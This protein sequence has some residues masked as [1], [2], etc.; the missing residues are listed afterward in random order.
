MNR[1][2]FSPAPLQLGPLQLS[3][4]E[5]HHL[6]HVLRATPGD[7]ITLF[8]G[9]GGEFTAR[10]ESTARKTVVCQILQA[11]S[12]NRELPVE[13]VLG[14]ALPKGER[15][16]WLI[17]KATELGVTRLVPVET[18]RSTQQHANNSTDRLQRTVIE[19]SK[20]CGRNQLMYISPTT[21][22]DAFLRA[23]P[24]ASRR[25]MAHPQDARATT[26]AVTPAMDSP[27]WLLVGPEGGFTENETAQART[28]GW[29]II[30]LGAR[31][32]R[33]ETAAIALTSLASLPIE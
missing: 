3:G 32:L 22:L 13:L 4:T 17:E 5:A 21:S 8:D 2:F 9:A 7:E 15:Q 1:R 31:I 19:S 6:L 14:V 33:V 24:A 12:V 26:A 20:Q 30:D 10:V 28:E 11:R 25:W 23:A 29:Q 18:S 16:R 27:T